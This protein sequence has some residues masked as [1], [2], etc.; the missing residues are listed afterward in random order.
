ME[1]E[2]DRPAAHTD[3]REKA[4]EKVASKSISEEKPS[5]DTVTSK[6]SAALP[7]SPGGTIGPVPELQAGDC[8]TEVKK[9]GEVW[10]K[11]EGEAEGEGGGEG[12]SGTGGG[13]AT[14]ST[15]E[16]TSEA[17]DLIPSL[18]SDGKESCPSAAQDGEACAADALCS[19]ERYSYIRRGFTSEIFK[20]EI[21][22]LPKYMGYTVS[23]K[24]YIKH[25]FF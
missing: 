6:G 4:S 8:S 7:Q 18:G 9:V 11:E 10:G 5:I 25:V 12:S 22:N 20:V 13:E 24:N 23:C 15:G 2:K 21:R 16:A 19:D 17:A 1:E 14:L 3:E